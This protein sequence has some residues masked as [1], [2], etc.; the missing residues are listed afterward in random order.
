MARVMT[1]WLVASVVVAGS[2]VAVGTPT[3]SAN[4]SA[5]GARAALDACDPV[6][7]YRRAIVS[8]RNAGGTAGAGDRF[9][10]VLASG[11]F[12]ADGYVDAVVGA[13]NDDI[14]GV[15]SGAV[16]V[17]RGSAAGTTTGVR[18]GQAAGGGAD[19]AGD[20]FGA[21]LAA[22]DFDGDGFAD[23]AVGAPTEDFNGV[24]DTGLVFVFRGSA[25]GLG[26]GTYLDQ[27]S[28]GGLNE[29][30]DRFGAAL[31]AANL[32]GDGTVD[33]AVGV[34]GEAPNSD[35][36]G[37]AVAVLRGSATGLG[38]GTFRTQADAAGASEAGDAFGAALAT[39]DVTGDDVVDLV[40]GAPNEA[41]GSAPA[42]GAVSVLP[43]PGLTGGYWREQGQAQGLTE[44]GDRFGAAVAAGDL[45]GDGVDEIVV[46]APGE[47]LSVTSTTTAADAGALFVLDQTGIVLTEYAGGD[48]PEASDALG[49]S[50]AVADLDSDGFSDVV[51]GAPGEG[52]DAAPS[53]AGSV[54][55]FGGRPG[56][57]DAGRRMEQ[58]Q[59]Q[60][61]SES[62]DRFGAALA[63][64]RSAA[65]GRTDVLVGA[66][67]EALDGFPAGGALA[68]VSGLGAN[69]S[70]GAGLGAV[71][72]TS[73][74]V[75]ARGT[76][77]S[78]LRAQY[79]VA[80][81]TAWTTTQP[82]TFNPALDHTAVLS[83]TGLTV[84]TTYDY[85]LVTGCAVDPL[86]TGRFRT[87]P[88]AGTPSRT[89]FVYGADFQHP[90]VFLGRSFSVLDHVAA[91]DSDFAI[92]GGDQ[93]YADFGTPATTLAGYLGKYRENWSQTHFRRFVGNR[94]TF[95][96][97]DDHE[98]AN[99]WSA[100]AAAPYPAAR[101]AFDAYQRGHSTTPVT[102]GALYY[103]FRAGQADFFV[104]DV[105]SHRSLNGAVDNASKTMLGATQ[106]AALKT[107][108]S[109]STGAFKLIV[110]AVP[111]NEFGTTGSD[112]WSGFRTER[113]E[114]FQYIRDQ[115]I[116]GVVLVAGD[117]H[118]SAAVRIDGAAS[119][120]LYEFMAT[121]MAAGTRTPPTPGPGVEWLDSQ[122][123]RAFGVFDIDTTVTPAQLT[124][125]YRSETNALMCRIRID[126]TGSLLA[127]ESCT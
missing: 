36:A 8:A 92:F 108:L 34:P 88:A 54:F 4:E 68:V 117:Q 27:S 2:V 29:G 58:G 33:L 7:S 100:G 22:G 78:E 41:P 121:P 123:R 1:L 116:P 81:T 30:G 69:L 35:A 87:L 96:M 76:H 109:Q 107:W 13:P 85:R 21:A 31:A 47:D 82:V 16:Y 3:S 95:V 56:A 55:V 10:E 14:G 17:F 104:L 18:I 12:D 74:R 11:D 80:G 83:L 86:T 19:E 25:S 119:Y 48:I 113:A 77:P 103:T 15:R 45:D 89:R 49:T 53:S 64:G 71:T 59:L 62:G 99:D 9:G 26:L 60:A 32:T 43:G 115:A 51:A 50:V 23:L 40:V 84:R 79:R 120:P 52:P 75:W 125:E 6:D 39:G 98:I 46:G 5:I 124:V 114:I 127:K 90:S 38:A 112:S 106:K 111:F 28:A 105:R 102:P 65:T 24:V 72:D 20:A 70:I 63:V 118:W 110:T 126:A 37:G 42:G 57:I 91:Y 93:M 97:W 66:T 44:G 73:V 61:A 67:G 101:A 122:L 94:P